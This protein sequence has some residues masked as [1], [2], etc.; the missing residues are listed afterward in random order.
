MGNDIAMKKAST[1]TKDLDL[2]NQ[3]SL[4]AATYTL[5]IFIPPISCQIAYVSHDLPDL[6]GL[7]HVL[8]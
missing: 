5:R 4:T 1:I 7:Y 3:I 8:P 6:A 2:L